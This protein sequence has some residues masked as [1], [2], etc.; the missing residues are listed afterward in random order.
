MTLEDFYT[1]LPNH[2]YKADVRRQLD[3]MEPERFTALED[4]MKQQ[5]H[6]YNKQFTR[7]LHRARSRVRQYVRSPRVLVTDFQKYLSWR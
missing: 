5:F 3:T 1:M 4:E 2:Y 7:I 6:L